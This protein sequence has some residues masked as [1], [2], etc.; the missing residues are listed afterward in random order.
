MRVPTSCP[1]SP[2][3]PT[4]PPLLPLGQRLS[5]QMEAVSSSMNNLL[6]H[7]SQYKPELACFQ[8][9]LV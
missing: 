9:N 6:S 5:K 2:P 4:S 3:P 1:P 7:M 8:L